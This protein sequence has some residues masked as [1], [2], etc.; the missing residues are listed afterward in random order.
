MNKIDEHFLSYLVGPA[1]KSNEENMEIGT[2]LSVIVELI[3]I[4]MDVVGLG[5]DFT[6]CIKNRNLGIFSLFYPYMGHF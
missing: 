5:R 6:E 4:P 2:G 1:K 3:D